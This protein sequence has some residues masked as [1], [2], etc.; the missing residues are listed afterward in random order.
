MARNAPQN[1]YTT[2]ATPEQSHNVFAQNGR[3][4][5]QRNTFL[6][7]FYTTARVTD[8]DTIT[9]LTFVARTVDRPKVNLKMEEMNQYNKKRLVYTGAKLE[10]V[11]MQF[12][13][14]GDASA[15]KLWKSYVNY[16]Y[17]DLARTASVNSSIAGS[18]NYDI[19]STE[20]RDVQQ[21]GFGFV[22]VDSFDAQFFFD[23]IEIYHFYDRL[24]DAFQ[25][26]HPRI[27]AFEPDDLD[28]ENGS[29]SLIS[30][31]VQYEALQ[32]L[33][34][35]DA[36]ADISDQPFF[37]FEKG[38]EF[39]GNVVPTPAT[40]SN[41]PARRGDPPAESMSAQTSAELLAN[42]NEGILSTAAAYRYSGEYA[43]GSLGTYGSYLYGPVG[44]QDIVGMALSNIAL[45]AAV[46]LG[47]GINPLPMVK[48]SLQAT[49]Y[50]AIARGIDA[51]TFDVAM[52]RAGAVTSPYGTVM[53]PLTSGLLAN[54]AINGDRSIVSPSGVVLAPESYGVI[55]MQQS[56]TAQYGYNPS[57]Q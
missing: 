39:D 55:N 35:N 54:M 27:V 21:T 1:G 52:S 14:S 48:R 45:S 53:N 49:A 11:R 34:H 2:V 31:S 51:A 47:M 41:P 40:M 44:T 32:C 5:K 42:V 15:L 6:V 36:G 7:K 57:Y 33:L 46:D 50:T 4:P 56:G 38:T 23:K 22:G 37:E 43:T 3:L 24:Y 26:I 10:P 18:Y 12:Y 8:I 20:F 16:Y 29:I 17:G 9:G 30:M 13:D 28:Y 19:V 25:L